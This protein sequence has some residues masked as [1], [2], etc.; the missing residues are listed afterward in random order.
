MAFI[1]LVRFHHLCSTQRGKLM[2]RGIK[3]SE[4]T[5]ILSGEEGV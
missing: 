5:R 1:A 3:G 2:K 4:R